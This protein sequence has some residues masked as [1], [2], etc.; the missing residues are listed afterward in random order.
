[1]TTIAADFNGAWAERW[2]EVRLAAKAN[3][4]A[5]SEQDSTKALRATSDDAASALWHPVDI[6]PRTGDRVTWR[7]KVE[8]PLVGNEF[9]RQKRGDDYAARLFVIFDAEPFSRQARAVCYVWAS[10]QPVGAVYP[11]PYFSN[12]TTVVLRSGP[13]QI[14]EWVH[15]E[16]DFV[17]DYRNAFGEGPEK[18]TAVAVMVD[19]DDTDSR[20]VA[21]FDTVELRTRSAIPAH[22]SEY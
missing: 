12:V 17:E 19:T 10:Q 3:R 1:M 5:V 9:E 13:E 18:V 14:G 4:F 16:R 21:W 2:E 15:E 7:W 6:A 11:N 22:E 20:A 8:R